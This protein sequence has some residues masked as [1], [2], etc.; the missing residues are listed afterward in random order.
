MKNDGKCVRTLNGITTWYDKGIS[1][2]AD[3]T[4]AI[5]EQ[6]GQD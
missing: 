1:Y 4:H 3:Q 6:L 2:K 5:V